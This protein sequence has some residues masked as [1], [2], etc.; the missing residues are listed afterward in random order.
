MAE[1]TTVRIREETRVAL[2]NME[3]LTGERPQELLALA[4]EELRRK[5]VLEQTSAAYGHAR[6]AGDAF[7]DLTAWDGTL[8][9]GLDDR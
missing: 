7:D 3:K 6:D 4:V 1:T 5:I 2:R 9:D 8:A